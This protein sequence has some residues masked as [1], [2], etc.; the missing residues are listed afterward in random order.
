MLLRFAFVI[1]SVGQIRPEVRAPLQA[2]AG[3][4]QPHEDGVSQ[5]LDVDA[6]PLA[7]GSLLDGELQQAEAFARIA[8][9]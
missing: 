4:A 1:P 3:H 5:L 6:E 7:P 8:V 9:A 2:G